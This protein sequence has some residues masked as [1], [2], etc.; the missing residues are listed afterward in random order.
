MEADFSFKFS[1]VQKALKDTNKPCYIS[2]LIVEKDEA[3]W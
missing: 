2:I 1:A 3:I